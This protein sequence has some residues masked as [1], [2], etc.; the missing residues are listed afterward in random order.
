V[1][2]QISGLAGQG[3]VDVDLECVVVGV[4]DSRDQVT[5]HL[6]LTGIRF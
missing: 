2:D 4:E 3:V 6:E 1:T 5:A